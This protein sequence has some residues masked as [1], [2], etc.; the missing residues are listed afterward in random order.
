MFCVLGGVGSREEVMKTQQ[1]RRE[2][3]LPWAKELDRLVAAEEFTWI[4][5][6][7]LIFGL[8]AI[9]IGILLGRFTRLLQ[10]ELKWTAIVFMA[11][12]VCVEMRWKYRFAYCVGTIRAAWVKR[13]SA[14]VN[15]C[16]HLTSLG[17]ALHAFAEGRTDWWITPFREIAS[18]IPGKA[19]KILGSVN[20]IDKSFNG[21][22]QAIGSDSFLAVGCSEVLAR[23]PKIWECFS[24]ILPRHLQREAFDPAFNDMLERYMGAHK[25]LGKSSQ[26]WLAF[27]FTICAIFIVLDCIRLM[28]MSSGGKLLLCL[29]PE[30]LRAW[31]RRL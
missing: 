2:P 18:S 8:I 14:L 29:F 5:R 16:G 25:F 6:R 17:D 10:V 27:G 21:L 20:E 3:G 19:Q 12:L 26:R 30:S 7:I 11:A 22:E 28:L 24:Y 13:R 23:L 15:V 31:W 4:A 1:F 9:L